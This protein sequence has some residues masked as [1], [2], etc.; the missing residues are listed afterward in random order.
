MLIE[1]NRFWKRAEVAAAYS[2]PPGQEGVIDAVPTAH[3]DEITGEEYVLGHDVDRVIA[4]AFPTV[5]PDGPYPPD[6]IRVG[7]KDYS[8][9]SGLRWRLLRC[10]WGRGPVAI[11]E[12]IDAIWG[13]DFDEGDKAL[14]SLVKHARRWCRTARCPLGLRTKSGYVELLRTS[15]EE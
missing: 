12:V 1:M 15:K 7:G 10:L 4:G 11:D 3:S 13:Q 9:V 14:D 5:R 6:A 8:G 2:I